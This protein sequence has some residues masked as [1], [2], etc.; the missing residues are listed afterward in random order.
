MSSETVLIIGAKGQIG[1]VLTKELQLKF[2]IEN[3]VASDLREDT[4]F[5]GHFEVIDAT[6]YDRIEAVVKQYGITQIYHLAAILSAKGEENP[7]LT[8]EI[9]MKTMFNVFEVA[10]KNGVQKVFYPSSIAVFGDAAPADATPQSTYLNPS[11]V[12]GISKSAGENW[13]EY[14]FNRYG[15]D[16]RSI[17]YPG[18]IGYQSLPGGG[19]TDYAVDIYH[20]AVNEEDFS[21]FLNKDSMLPMIFMDDAIRAT[22]ELMD[23]PKESIKTRSSYNLAG[24]SFAPEEIAQA[25]QKILPNF[26]ISY[27]P[28][29]RQEIAANWPRSIDDSDARI[30]WGWKPQYDLDGMTKVMLEKLK[31]QY[32]TLNY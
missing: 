2:G 26:K 24:M 28:D 29:F 8:W 1:S 6:N 3:V 17:R 15:L 10:R 19:T 4:E 16:I 22:I 25:I 12:Y 5:I 9:N 30:D 32:S 21:C 14:Y 23:A 27:A 13:S 20:K 11:T 18:I 31:E 7:L